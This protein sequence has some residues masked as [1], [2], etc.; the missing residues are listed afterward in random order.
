MRSQNKGQKLFCEV[1]SSIRPYI[2]KSLV[3]TILQNFH[4]LDHPGQKECQ[5]RIASNYFWPRLSKDVSYFVKRCH[6]CQSAKSAKK[7]KPKA[8]IFK[9]PEERFSQ[10]HTDI[11]GPLPESEGMKF[12]L[13][14][15]CRR[16]RWLECVPLPAAT[17]MNVCNGFLRTW[18]ARYGCPQEIFCDNGNTYTANLWQDLNRV[19]GIEVTFV[20]PYHQATNGAIERQHMTLKE[21]IKASLIGMG[22][23]HRENWMKQLPFTF[24]GRRVALQQDLGTSAAELTLGGAPVL[25]SVFVPDSPKQQTNTHELLKTVQTNVSQPPV[26]M[27]HHSKPKPEDFKEPKDFHSA[28][29]VYV[30]IDKPV[31][32]GNK[33]QGP[34]IIVSLPSNTVND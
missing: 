24:Q 6:A 21:S 18:L 15:L 17:S 16:T 32:L 2:P 12:L 9:A 30:R 5:F 22:D 20:P 31:N 23:T 13:T 25:P 10:L 8:K 29:H 3:P 28:T 33:F 26:P 11:V 14:I 7:I 19:L 4:T 34:F 1:S 27:S